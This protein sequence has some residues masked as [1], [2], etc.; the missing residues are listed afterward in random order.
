MCPVYFSFSCQ[1]NRV[2][3]HSYVNY[4]R[5]SLDLFLVK[6]SDPSPGLSHGSSAAANVNNPLFFQVLPRADVFL[7]VSD[8]AVVSAV[9]DSC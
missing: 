2:G 8:S 1:P 9:A 5:D 4:T 3:Q 7:L 6:G